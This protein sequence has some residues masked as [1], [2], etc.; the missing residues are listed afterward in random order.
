METV[1]DRLRDLRKRAGSPTQKVVAKAVGCAYRSYQNWEQG[2][3][4]AASGRVV[5]PSYRNAKALARYFDTTPEYILHG[6]D[7]DAPSRVEL[8]Q[9]D[10]K[11][12]AALALLTALFDGELPDSV[13]ALQAASGS[14]GA[15][16]QGARGVGRRLAAQEPVF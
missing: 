13:A 11:L 10:A 15:R 3:T 4:S 2:S 16:P 5:V 9:L 12:D 1:A 8:A 7:S 14:R 6:V